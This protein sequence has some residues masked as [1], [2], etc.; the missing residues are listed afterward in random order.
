M[1]EQ[2]THK[3]VTFNPINSKATTHLWKM[4]PIFQDG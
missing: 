1:T 4:F 2:N 3:N